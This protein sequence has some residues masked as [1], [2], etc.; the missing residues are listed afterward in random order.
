MRRAALSGSGSAGKQCVGRYRRA[1]R[2]LLGPPS[3]RR[4][5]LALP[6]WFALLA[7]SHGRS[8]EAADS[9]Q[10][11]ADSRKRSALE[12]DRLQQRSPPPGTPV[13][14]GA[15]E[16]ACRRRRADTG[17]QAAAEHALDVR[18]IPAA[19]R[20]AV[21]RGPPP[22]PSSFGR[23]TA[24]DGSRANPST[25][26][27]TGP[28]PRRP[29]SPA[30]LSDPP[31]DNGTSSPDRR[32]SASRTTPR[33]TARKAANHPRIDPEYCRKEPETAPKC[34]GR[35]RLLSGMASLQESISVAD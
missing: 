22:P 12:S 31:P 3:S 34:S 25:K 17:R 24:P 4:C 23:S 6:G 33:Q 14:P 35:A 11:T 8:E 2:R 30:T 27:P 9:R 7:A 32:L 18:H 21:P 13:T 20:A 1:R 15:N 28:A 29:P 16:V 26:N 19:C 5:S 10:R